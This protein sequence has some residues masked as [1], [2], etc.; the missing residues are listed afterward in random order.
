MHAGMKGLSVAAVVAAALVALAPAASA[1]I[2]DE[3]G[4]TQSGGS[5]HGGQFSAWAYYAQAH[6][7][8]QV[9]DD[10]CHLQK[11]PELPA[12]YEYN[13]VTSDGGQTYTVFYDCVLDGKNVDDVN[14]LYPTFGEEWDWLDTWTVTPADPQEMIAQAIAHLN[15][16]PPKV[17]TSPG[18]GNPGLVNLPVYLDFATPLGRVDTSFSDGPL[19]VFL[20]ARNPTVSWDTGDGLPACNAPAGPGGVCTHLFSQSSAGQ[21]GHAFTITAT[22]TYTG[23]YVVTANGV[24]VGGRNN[25]GNI[26]RTSTTTLAVNE[27]QAINDDG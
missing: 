11:H 9:L 26:Q 16:T 17:V 27:A 22:I 23:S 7:E 20:S 14:H 24:P 8:G 6:G 4:T 1:G 21:S 18:G 25:I 2:G 13:V 5:N 19:T 12:H 3:T 15:P 10:T